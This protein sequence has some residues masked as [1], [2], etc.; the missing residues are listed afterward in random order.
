MFLKSRVFINVAW[1][2][3][4]ADLG[5]LILVLVIN[6]VQNCLRNWWP[7]EGLLICCLSM[8]SRFNFD[9]CRQ[10]L[11]VRRSHNL[12]IN[13]VSEH[14]IDAFHLH[15]PRIKPRYFS[16]C[17]R[18]RL[19]II[20]CVEDVHRLW[21][22]PLLGR[23]VQMI[24]IQINLINIQLCLLEL[25]YVVGSQ[26]IRLIYLIWNMFLSQLVVKIILEYFL[27]L[28]QAVDKVL[29][30]LICLN[31]NLRHVVLVRPIIIQILRPW[32]MECRRGDGGS[33]N[34]SAFFLWLDYLQLLFVL[35]SWAPPK[36]PPLS[37]SHRY[38]FVNWP[39]LAIFVEV[40]VVLPLV[41]KLNVFGVV[42]IS[43][44]L[45]R[46]PHVLRWFWTDKTNVFSLFPPVGFMFLRFDNMAVPFNIMRL[47]L[48]VESW[49]RFLVWNLSQLFCVSRFRLHLFGFVYHR[50]S[51]THLVLKLLLYT[52]LGLLH[53]RILIGVPE[54]LIKGLLLVF[55]RDTT[56]CVYQL[57][58]KW[59]HYGS[60][61][62]GWNAWI[63]EI[64]LLDLI[65]LIICITFV[66]I[67][68]TDAH[69]IWVYVATFV[70]FLRHMLLNNEILWAHFYHL[71]VY[72][73]H[74]LCR[75][76]IYWYHL[77]SLEV[78]LWNMLACTLFE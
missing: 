11:G 66:S 67:E 41:R 17:T 56:C 21:L 58:V 35:L 6:F 37:F 51:V 72:W 15:S 76:V 26:C 9:W 57:G 5:M 19:V 49:L 38:F 20:S 73:C 48:I 12:W 13:V 62:V 25:N 60:V 77:V 65:V 33:V 3:H 50:I 34:L 31:N 68:C 8:G 4:V 55:F 7:P 14:G 22:L 42:E 2:L 36:L 32:R 71:L 10:N 63:H 29:L 27:L 53:L 44:D 16:D 54:L 61:T 24:S 75:L 59:L 52:I 64:D 18:V 43:V 69:Y 39:F 45:W 74:L 47:W 70:L 23:G 1:W 46:T 28:K 30:L 78:L 40:D